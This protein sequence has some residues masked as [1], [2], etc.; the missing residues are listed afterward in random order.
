MLTGRACFRCA[1]SIWLI[2]AVV[3]TSRLQAAISFVQ[4]HGGSN[5][6]ATSAAVEDR[7]VGP[8]VKANK[9]LN[10]RMK[11]LG[12]DGVADLVAPL[13]SLNRP[14]M[15]QSL[16]SQPS[17]VESGTFL[18][19][20][21]LGLKRRSELTNDLSFAGGVFT[22]SQDSIVVRQKISQ[23]IFEDFFRNNYLRTDRRSM[24]ASFA[25]NMNSKRSSSFVRAGR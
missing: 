20:Q 12:N 22:G 10:E 13:P 8:P 16:R 5:N 25:R 17:T 7:P 2:C 21:A 19:G 3:S 11:I 24:R 1:F 23:K 4:S 9:W 6:P 15:I 14:E 18:G